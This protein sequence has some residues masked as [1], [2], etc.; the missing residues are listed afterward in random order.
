MIQVWTNTDIHGPVDDHLYYIVAGDT[1][2]EMSR[3]TTSN[4]VN[5]GEWVCSLEDD[6][7]G[8]EISIGDYELQ[9]DY[10]Q[11][12]QLLAIL[13]ASHEGKMEI[14]KTVTTKSI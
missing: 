1:T 5:P 8:V 10:C 9:L 6:G 12:E 4:W 11:Y 14:R 3:S 2:L 7:N 13:L